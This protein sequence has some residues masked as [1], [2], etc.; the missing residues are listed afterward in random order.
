MF[1][2]NIPGRKRSLEFLV[3]VKNFIEC[4]TARLKNCPF[5]ELPVGMQ[6]SLL[7]GC[8]S[9]RGARARK[10]QEDGIHDSAEYGQVT[11]ESHDLAVRMIFGVLATAVA[12]LARHHWLTTL[13]RLSR[14]P[15]SGLHHPRD[16][17]LSTIFK[18]SS[19]DSVSAEFVPPFA[20]HFAHSIFTAQL[21]RLPEVSARYIPTRLAW[22]RS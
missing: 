18:H 1:I 13:Q 14:K 16:T 19:G 11:E 10:L 4:R 9:R 15:P 12:A 3:N 6:L 22:I 5:G 21:P 17:H 2:G 7:P 20:R 8:C